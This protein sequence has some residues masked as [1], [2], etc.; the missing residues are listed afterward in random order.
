METRWIRARRVVATWTVLAGLAA[1]LGGC[2]VSASGHSAIVPPTVL[3]D[4]DFSVDQGWTSNVPADI[5]VDTT[6]TIARWHAR[7]DTIQHMTRPLTQ[8]I[9]GDFTLEATAEID[10]FT[11]NSDIVIGLSTSVE[12]A[13]PNHVPPGIYVAIGYFGGGCWNRSTHATGLFVN[14]QGLA[15][16]LHRGYVCSQSANDP[17]SLGN[18]L[19]IPD[20][21]SI[22][23]RLTISGSDLTLEAY[24]EDTD[25]LLGVQT[26]TVTG[27]MPTLRYA[28]IGNPGDGDWPEAFGSV[29]RIL[30]TR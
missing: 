17:G 14:D 19:T 1:A 8:T 2:G 23:I 4:D 22:R 15:Q 12:A 6:S 9:S 27:T 11:N 5:W 18:M 20:A 30:V 3:F 10:R 26:V 24:F 25:M 28:Y 13:L 21:T 29:D 7:R 16:G